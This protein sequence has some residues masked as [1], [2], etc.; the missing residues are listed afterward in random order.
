M[1]P[2]PTVDYLAQF[3]G[4]P[5]S[6][7]TPFADTALVQATL[8]FST[9]TQRTEYPTDEDGEQL[10]INAILEMAERLILE[11]PYAEQKARPFSSETIG[12]YSYSKTAQSAKNGENTGLLWWDLAIDHLSLAGSSIV[13]SGAVGAFEREDVATDSDGDRTILGPATFV[14]IPRYAW[15]N[16]EMNPRPRLG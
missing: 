13:A 7:F 15:V 10:A 16:A 8:L 2:V 4:R 11:K 12:S 5:V 9:I 6:S 1:L 14:D 3:T